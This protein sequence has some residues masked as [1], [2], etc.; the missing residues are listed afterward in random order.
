MTVDQYLH[1]YGRTVYR[2]VRWLQSHGVQPT[3]ALAKLQ[4]FANENYNFQD[5][6]QLDTVLLEFCHKGEILKN[7]QEFKNWWSENE[8]LFKHVP[9]Y[10]K[11][12]KALNNPL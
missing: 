8:H 10:K 4:L 6:H 12:W 11:V 7:N 3:V 2:E 1:V 9:W 5:G